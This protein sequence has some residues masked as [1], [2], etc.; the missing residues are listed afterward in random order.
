M[1]TRILRIREYE[2]ADEFM[3]DVPRRHGEQLIVFDY[4]P[5]DGWLWSTCDVKP[6]PATVA[7]LARLA[8]ATLTQLAEDVERN[9]IKKLPVG[10]WPDVARVPPRNLNMGPSK[11]TTPEDE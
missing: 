4:G 3:Q 10:Q 1:K 11:P 7:S 5:G 9:G 2:S 8:A 6:D